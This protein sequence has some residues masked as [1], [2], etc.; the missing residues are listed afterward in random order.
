MGARVCLG[1]A[2]AV[3]G[4]FLSLVAPTP[5]AQ[6]QAETPSRPDAR[7]APDAMS[8]A[9]LFGAA[10]KNSD[11][12]AGRAGGMMFLPGRGLIRWETRGKS[13]AE[14]EELRTEAVGLADARAVQ[15]EI[16]AR[17][18]A[19]DQVRVSGAERLAQLREPLAFAETGRA[20]RALN[21]APVTGTQRQAGGVIPL[22][23]A[24][25]QDSLAE[26][27]GVHDGAR[28]RG[29]GRLYVFG[30]VSGRG[31]GMNLLHD[32]GAGWRNAGLSSDKGGFIGQRQAGLALRRGAV[33]A[34]LSFVQEKTHAHILGMTSIKDHRAMLSLSL[35]PGLK[36]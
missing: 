3:T 4:L 24:A 36:P 29:K 32:T 19:L 34:A 17:Q 12:S 22:N 20:A 27:L 11:L 16:D 8:R 2:T 33:Q 35:I 5:P 30:A 9:L 1:A 7:S 14:Q 23:R 28:F 13:A 10:Y 26:H 31:V 21:L 18:A 25:A 6:A 15:A